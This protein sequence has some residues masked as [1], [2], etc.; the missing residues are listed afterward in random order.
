MII[1]TNISTSDL[2]L[3]ETIIGDVGS[4][5][6]TVNIIGSEGNG[7]RAQSAVFDI[8]TP[9]EPT[10]TS[11]ASAA[12]SSG[13]GAVARGNEGRFVAAAV[14]EVAFFA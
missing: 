5:S 11:A 13:G 8:K 4:F 2:R 6:I 7:A 14:G 1:G 10:T 3:I 9:L 12:W